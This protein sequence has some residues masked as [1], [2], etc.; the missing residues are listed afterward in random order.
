MLDF[1]QGVDKA[2]EID[3]TQK[4]AQG[5]WSPPQLHTATTFGDEL[6]ISNSG[7]SKVFGVSVKDRGAISL[8]GHSGKAFWFSKAQSEFVTSNYYYD[9]YPALSI[10]VGMKKKLQPNTLSKSGSY[11]YHVKTTPCKN[12]TR[13]HK[14]KLGD[15]HRTFLTHTALQA[16]IASTTLTV[17]QLAMRLQR[18]LQ[19][20]C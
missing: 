18:T 15:F 1:R 19:A 7:K 9:E 14:V 10:H 6:M 17:S 2:T 13:D 12:T 20:R 4:T 8:A 3:P 5:G 16:R 11:H